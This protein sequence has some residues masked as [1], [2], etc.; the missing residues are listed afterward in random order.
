MGKFPISSDAMTEI[1]PTTCTLIDRLLLYG[2]RYR[3][4]RFPD[5][6]FSTNNI[7][8]CHI[9]TKIINIMTQGQPISWHGHC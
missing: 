2:A 6:L 5:I 7:R 1:E 8:L 4:N 9:L 3:N